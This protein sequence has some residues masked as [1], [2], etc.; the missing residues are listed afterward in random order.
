LSRKGVVAFRRGRGEPDSVWG[1]LGKERGRPYQITREKVREKRKLQ[2]KR[3]R[4]IETDL[5]RKK[6]MPGSKKR[7]QKKPGKKARGRRG[8]AHEREGG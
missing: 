4:R 3:V 2:R 6:S 1:L 8:K 7:G 5:Q